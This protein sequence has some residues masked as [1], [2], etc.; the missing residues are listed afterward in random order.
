MSETQQTLATQ[1]DA[2]DLT[3][4]SIVLRERLDEM[5]AKLAGRIIEFEQVSLEHAE[6]LDAITVGD[7]SSYEVLSEKVRNAVIFL[8]G[9][10][11]FFE[12]WRTLFYNPYKSL[13]DRKASVV[14]PTERA[15]KTA[16]SRLVRYNEEMKQ[17]AE[18]AA[19][20]LAEQQ[21]RDEEARKLEL[22]AQAET[23]GMSEQAVQAILETPSTTPTPTADRFYNMPQIKGQSTRESWKAEVF[24]FPALVVEAA[25]RFVKSKGK[26]KELFAYLEFNQVALNNQAKTHHAELVNVIPGV[27]GVNA[28]TLAIRR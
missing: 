15:V 1:V 5:Q 9:A 16:K 20:I 22:A 21:R 27:R 25:R 24:D 28:G 8:D 10:G 26:D 13:I 18:A 14:D 11:E 6:Q 23:A 17:K 19:R 7:A 4:M 12:P 2:S 3:V